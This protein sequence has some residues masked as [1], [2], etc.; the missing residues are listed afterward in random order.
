VK[1]SPD[2]QVPA[3]ANQFSQ[4]S[5]STASVSAIGAG[6]TSLCELI[7]HAATPNTQDG[8]QQ[9]IVA[10]NW[11][12]QKQTTC[13]LS[14]AA[15]P[16]LLPKLARTCFVQQQQTERQYIS[17]IY[18]CASVTAQTQLVSSPHIWVAL[19]YQNAASRLH[20]LYGKVCNPCCMIWL[21]TAQI[22]HHHVTVPNGLD[23]E[24][25]V[26]AGHGI[27]RSVQPIKHG[28]DLQQ[29]LQNRVRCT[30][31]AW[32]SRAAHDKENC[33]TAELAY[34]CHHVKPTAAS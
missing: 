33:I 11:Q 8:T 17:Q 27:K 13:S 16:S 5:L 6:W 22:S 31:K 23:L 18:A 34:P 32:S 1:P 2:A 3:V 12:L 15:S 24:Q 20:S 28:H 4:L 9:D 30:Q 19:T 29:L 21:G 14:S 26:A 10:A 7:L 25:V